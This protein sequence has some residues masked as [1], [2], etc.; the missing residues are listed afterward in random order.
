MIDP[1]AFLG[2][3]ETQSLSTRYSIRCNDW[4]TIGADL[5]IEGQIREAGNLIAV[6]PRVW[7]VARCQ[8]VLQ[9]K[10]YKGGVADS[11]RIA[12][13]FADDLVK[14]IT[15]RLGVAETEIAFISDRT[16]TREV[17]VMD[18]DGGNARQA[19]RSRSV[20]SFPSWSPDGKTLLYSSYRQARRP[21]LYSISKGGQISG[22]IGGDIARKQKVYRGVFDPSGRRIALVMADKES[23]LEIYVSDIDGRHLRILTEGG[24]GNN[25]SPSWSPDGKRLV[26][27]SDRTGS[28]QLYIIDADGQNLRRLTFTGSYNSAPAWSPDGN[29]IAYEL[30]VEAQFDIWLIDPE[31]KVNVPLVTH[32]RSDEMPTWAPD[33]RKLAF[34]STRAGRA[35]IYVI[36][37][38]GKNL[39]RLTGNAGQN[40]SPAWG[41][42]LHD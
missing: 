27:V 42:Y 12:K 39:R 33:S 32:R 21:A 38:N 8:P 25:L 36:D 29:W 22:R 37:L 30:R 34:S 41:P 9:G 10:R 15:G 40:I 26:F 24:R 13:R 2:S 31:G 23:Q 14:E 3:V 6:G 19:T 11:S 1:K 17:W 4:R 7:D 20:N 35:D 28:P 16:G 5:F 18:A